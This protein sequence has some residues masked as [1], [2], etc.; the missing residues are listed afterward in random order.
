MSTT[1]EVARSDIVRSTVPEVRDY[2]EYRPYLRRDFYYS[3][4]YCTMSE[5]EAT[6]IRFTI[7]HYESQKSSPHLRNV[8]DNLLYCCDEC[9]TRK[10]TQALSEAV[11]R[12][13]IRLFR[14]DR[15][16]RDEHLVT[17]ELRVEGKTAIGE[18]T[19]D[20]VALNRSSLRRLREIRRRLTACSEFVSE[21]VLG[22]RE[23]P[24]DA[25]P[26]EIKSRA[27]NAVKEATAA[28]DVVVNEIDDLLRSASRSPLDGGELTLE[29]VRENKERLKRVKNVQA[30]YPENW[31][32]PFG[33]ND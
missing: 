15:D 23:F 10:G 32:R 7:D 4:A 17:T 20:A 18:Y 22:L 29:E 33:S 9:N 6:A 24:L 11:R 25:L 13:G 1:T 19:V 12:L 14:P 26:R 8:Y 2:T 31:H 5:A 30:L 3:C 28:V 21:G 27:F 16:A